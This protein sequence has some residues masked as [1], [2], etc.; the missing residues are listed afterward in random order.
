MAAYSPP[1]PSFPLYVMSVFHK[2]A[3]PAQ[4]RSDTVLRVTVYKPVSSPH[5]QFRHARPFPQ[6]VSRHV[7]L[8]FILTTVPT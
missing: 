4:A 8:S 6:I 7:K 3:F 5:E 1:A 2:L